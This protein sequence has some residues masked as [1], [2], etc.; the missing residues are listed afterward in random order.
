MHEIPS[1]WTGRRVLLRAIEPEDWESYWPDGR[2]SGSQRTGYEI[3]FPRSRAR[4]RELADQQS[5]RDAERDEFRFAIQSIDT[6]EVVGAI[7]THGAS[8][9]NGAFEYGIAVFRKHWRKGYASEAILLVLRYYFLELRYH[10][11]LATVYGFNEPSLALHRR[12]GFV[13][14]GRLREQIYT[15]GA[16]HDEYIFGM[17]SDEFLARHGRSPGE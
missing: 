8:A 17:T 13:E 12:L 4:A 3:T 10:K 2:D 5:H 6:G 11:V 9:R 7:N 14:E 1:V 15:G 16:Y